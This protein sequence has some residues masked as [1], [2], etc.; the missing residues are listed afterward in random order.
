MTKVHSKFAETGAVNEVISTIKRLEE[1]VAT[2]TD[3]I[4]NSRKN[5]RWS[6][7]RENERCFY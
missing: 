6:N 1:S 7:E 5:N 2:L 3:Y 4:K